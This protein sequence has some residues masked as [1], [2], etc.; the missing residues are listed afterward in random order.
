MTASDGTASWTRLLAGAV[1]HDINNFVQGVSSARALAGAP[2]AVGAD[3]AETEAIIEDDLDQLRKLGGRLR[4]LA[5]AGRHEVATRI[6]DACADAFAEVDRPLEEM[7]AESIPADL[8]VVGTADSVTTA[9]ASLMEHALAASPAGAAVSLPIREP[10]AAGAAAAGAPARPRTGTP[11]IVAIAAP[12]AALLGPI[13]R[14]RL[15]VALASS[16]PELRGDAP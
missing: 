16:L 2:G 8:C 10:R 3:A 4:A 6:T 5:S 11:V 14:A 1:A 12:K 9:I 13:S 15:D 7:R